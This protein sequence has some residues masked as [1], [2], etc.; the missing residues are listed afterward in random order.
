MP[1]ETGNSSS[2]DNFISQML[3]FAVANAGFTMGTTVQTSAGSGSQNVRSVV[4]G[5]VRWSFFYDPYGNSTNGTDNGIAG[6]MSYTQANAGLNINGSFLSKHGNDFCSDGMVGLAWGRLY[7]FTGPYPNHWFFTDG[8]SVH[9]VLEISTGLFCHINFGSVTK[10]GAWTGGEFIGISGAM[11]T[12]GFLG[13]A[14]SFCSPFDGGTS[15][16]YPAGSQST[17]GTIFLR[18]NN[19]NV[20]ADFARQ[21]D[22]SYGYNSTSGYFSA[23]PTGNFDKSMMADLLEN[24]PSS[25]AWRTILTPIIWFRVNGTGRVYPAAHVPNVAFTRMTDV[26]VNGQL[27]ETDWRIFPIFRRATT[28]GGLPYSDNWAIAYREV[29]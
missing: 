13:S 28:S 9:A 14:S 17:T 29:A 12:V 2:I 19:A 21:G 7:G 5:G 27:I 20:S 22:Q 4:K 26:M 15:G 3:S 24:M 25:S 1:F 16:N 11:P 23:G 8:V 18:T 6:F 10:Y